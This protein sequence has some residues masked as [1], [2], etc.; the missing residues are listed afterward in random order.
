MLSFVSLHSFRKKRQYN[1]RVIEVEVV[2][3]GSFTPLVS[4]NKEGVCVCV[5]G[6]G[7]GEGMVEKL[8]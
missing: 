5:W 7:G 4:H 6:R 3:H 8:S 2:E 1:Q